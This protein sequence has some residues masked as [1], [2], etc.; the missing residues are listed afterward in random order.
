MRCPVYR[1]SFLFKIDRAFQRLLLFR[2]QAGRLVLAVERHQPNLPL[3]L[4]V[5]I[6]DPQTTSATFSTPRVCA[7]HLSKAAGP[8]HHIPKIRARDEP[9]L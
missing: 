5:E 9:R 2:S 1:T 4:E 7:S 8:R 3:R 6:D